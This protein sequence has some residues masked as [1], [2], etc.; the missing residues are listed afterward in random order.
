MCIDSSLGNRLARI[1]WSRT[2]FTSTATPLLVFRRDRL[3]SAAGFPMLFHSTVR[4]DYATIRKVAGSGPDEMEFFNLPNPSSLT[5]ALGSTQPLTVEYQEYSCGVK[6]GRRV[7]L[8]SLTPSVSRL[9][10][11]CGS[12]PLRTLWASTALQG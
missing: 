6:G 1:Y 9:S 4:R 3:Y 8:R 12:L 7:R 2:P 10:R 5:M 11:K